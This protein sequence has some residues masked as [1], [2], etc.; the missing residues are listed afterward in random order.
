ML[1]DRLPLP[2]LKSL[3]PFRVVKTEFK[4]Y[5][6]C[7]DTASKRENVLMCCIVPLQ[8]SIDEKI[9]FKGNHNQLKK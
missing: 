4:F 2:D 1:K 7:R 9:D 8:D 5:D 3:T 6:A